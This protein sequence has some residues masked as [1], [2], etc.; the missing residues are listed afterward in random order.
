MHQ[1][2]PY[3]KL[4]RLGLITGPLFGLLGATP[5]LLTGSLELKRIPFIFFIITAI[6]YVF[7]AI[8]ISLSR[9]GDVFPLLR[10]S[11]LRCLLSLLLAALVI[12]LV[13]VVI[14]PEMPAVEFPKALKGPIMPRRAILFPLI[15]AESINII[16]MVLVELVLVQEEKW[17][18]QKENSQLKVANLEAKHNHLKQQLHPHFLFNSLGT[19]RSLIKRS[20]EKAEEYLEKLTGI[21]RSSVYSNV[22]TLVSLNEELELSINYLSMLQVRFGTALNYSIDIPSV[23]KLNGSVPVYSIQLLIENAIKHNI[24]TASKPLS[25]FISGNEYDKW[26]NVTNNFQEKRVSDRTSGMGLANLSERYKLLGM[27]DIIIT[28][29]KNEFT[30]GIKVL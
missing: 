16:I 14:F 2:I 4:V 9:V 10:K 7:W 19:L 29:T 3:K 5:A 20:P 12:V 11:W 26:V 6:A 18:V 27:E 25:I 23:M 28:N 13:I 24:L 1:S 17:H 22:Q 21:L 15:P 30:V 8:N